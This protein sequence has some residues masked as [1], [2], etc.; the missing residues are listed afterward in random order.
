MVSINNI[1]SYDLMLI[2]KKVPPNNHI[3]G[4]QLEYENIDEGV[5]K[6]KLE[7]E[8]KMEKL[9]NSY[10][11][12][13]EK[14]KTYNKKYKHHF[15]NFLLSVIETSERQEIKNL[16]SNDLSGINNEVV[17]LTDDMCYNLLSIDNKLMEDNQNTT[18][19][20]G[21]LNNFVNVSNPSQQIKILPRIVAKR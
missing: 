3:L 17:I 7:I 21:N 9:L 13:N 5:R 6:Y 2:N 14:E 20:I 10:L 16:V 4:K 18:K 12:D 8:T 11:D 15:H 19:K 1:N